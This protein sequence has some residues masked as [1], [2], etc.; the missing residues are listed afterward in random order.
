MEKIAKDPSKP[1]MNPKMFPHY[2]LA[3][4]AKSDF[5]LNYSPPQMP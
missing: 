1:L 2:T 3:S 4:P 5:G